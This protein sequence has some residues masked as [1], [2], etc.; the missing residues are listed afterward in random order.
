MAALDPTDNSGVFIR[1]PRFPRNDPD[2]D[3]EPALA[4]GYEVQ[5]DDRGID[6]ESGA[7]DSPLHCTGAIYKRAPA[8][9]RA[10]TTPGDW[11]IFAVHACDSALAVHLDGTL[12]SRLNDPGGPRTGY[13]GLQAHDE[14]SRVQFRRVEMR[15]PAG[16]R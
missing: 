6:H 3:W 4:R 1:I 5:I 9:V 14:R 11:N 10:S 12:V 16:D 8:I 7:A 13:I 15:L 2:H